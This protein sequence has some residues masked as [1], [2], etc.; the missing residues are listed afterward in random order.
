MRGHEDDVAVASVVRF[1]V[2]LAATEPLQGTIVG[3]N[4]LARSFNGW[5]SFMSALAE[6]RFAAPRTEP[7]ASAPAGPDPEHATAGGGTDAS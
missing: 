6:L 1:E 4:G 7:D 2:E 5:I 3:A